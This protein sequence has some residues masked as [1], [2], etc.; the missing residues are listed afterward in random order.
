MD[1]HMSEALRQYFSGPRLEATPPGSVSYG[2][3]CAEDVRPLTYEERALGEAED[4]S[5]KTRAVVYALLHLSGALERAAS[6]GLAAQN[7]EADLAAAPAGPRLD[8][9]RSL[10]YLTSL[11]RVL[12]AHGIGWDERAD[13]T[14]GGAPDGYRI[15]LDSLSAASLE[16][17][18][19]A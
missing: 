4:G 12:D 15:G 8:P 5:S 2:R 1:E 14:F 17:A 18:L 3:G 19:A 7:V 10:P 11:R 13:F 16:T 6:V 9:A